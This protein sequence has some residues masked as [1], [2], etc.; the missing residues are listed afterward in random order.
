MMPDIFGDGRDGVLSGSVELTRD[1]YYSS[2]ESHA[3]VKLNGFR[4]FIQRSCVI[5]TLTNGMIVFGEQPTS[6]T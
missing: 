4:M 1:M 3:R 6:R 2:V 5:H